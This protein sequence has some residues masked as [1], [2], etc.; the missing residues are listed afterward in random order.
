MLAAF[1][2][3]FAIVIGCVTAVCT[4][5]A[6]RDGIIWNIEIGR[7]R[8]ETVVLNREIPAYKVWLVP[9][10]TAIVAICATAPLI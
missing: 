6:H 1:I 8:T 2:Y 4:S 7:S 10:G 3:G 9:C 5:I